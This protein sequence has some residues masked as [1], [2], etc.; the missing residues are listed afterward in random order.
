MTHGATCVSRP[1]WVRDSCAT[2]LRGQG[3]VQAIRMYAASN[4]LTCWLTA[5]LQLLEPGGALAE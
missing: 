4:G 1:V 2:E 5:I 3:L